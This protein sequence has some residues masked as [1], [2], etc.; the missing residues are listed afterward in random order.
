MGTGEI[1]LNK[2]MLIGNLG[3][4]PEIRYTQSGT[5]VATFNV[6]TT[7]KYKGKDGNMV[8]STEWHRVVAWQKLA[9]ICGEYLHKGSK[10]YIEGKLQTRKWQDQNGNDKFTTEIVARDMQML[11]PRGGAGDEGYGGG[12][13][14]GSQEHS[15]QE[16]PS[17]MMGGG[18]R[19]DVPF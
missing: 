16:P 9:E 5:A 17:G 7:E 14:G 3:K 15:Y 10:V 6:A 2:V 8:E 4:D 1:M 12:G 18:S 13:G 19:D 11:S